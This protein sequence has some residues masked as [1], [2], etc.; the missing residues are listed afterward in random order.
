MQIGEQSDQ[1][2]ETEENGGVAVPAAAMLE[3]AVNTGLE[4]APE[5][6][7]NTHS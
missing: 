4:E 6:G 1:K 2:R 3:V 5:R 7:V